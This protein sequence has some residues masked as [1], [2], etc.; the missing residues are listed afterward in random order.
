MLAAVPTSPRGHYT[1]TVRE[2]AG[3]KYKV[4]SIVASYGN[5]LPIAAPTATVNVNGK[6]ITDKLSSDYGVVFTFY[7]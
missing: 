4:S 3:G 2:D 7:H 6:M 5:N 1:A